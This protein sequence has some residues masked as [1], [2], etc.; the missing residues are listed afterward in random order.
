MFVF[1]VPVIA[2]SGLDEGKRNMTSSQRQFEVLA[3]RARWAGHLCDSS[4]LRVCRANPR[5]AIPIRCITH[6]TTPYSSYHNIRPNPLTD[7]CFEASLTR[8]C[9]LFCRPA[10]P[11]DNAY[12]CFR[13]ITRDDRVNITSTR[14]DQSFHEHESRTR[15]ERTY[16]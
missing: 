7:P 8:N 9:T 16:T 4:P 12:I 14:S 3:R 6:H 2:G 10:I 13:A 11:E 15:I 5:T 1:R